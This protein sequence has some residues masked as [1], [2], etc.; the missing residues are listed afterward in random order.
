M[1]TCDH[2][3]CSLECSNHIEVAVNE[4]FRFNIKQGILA[5]C[6]RKVTGEQMHNWEKKK[7]NT[8]MHKPSVCK[9]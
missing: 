3:H 4:K 1:F 7:A 9:T 2:T 5:W 6:L 8:S